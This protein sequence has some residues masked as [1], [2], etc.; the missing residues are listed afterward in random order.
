A[1]AGPPSPTPRSTTPKTG[2]SRP[3]FL[4]RRPDDPDLRPE[5]A[6]RQ[7]KTHRVLGQQP[8]FPIQIDA[9][10]IIL[11]RQPGHFDHVRR[12]SG[13]ALKLGLKIDVARLVP[14]SVRVSD[15]GRHQLLAGAQQVHVVF[16]LSGQ[17]VQHH[18]A[19]PANHAPRIT[20][21]K[22]KPLPAGRGKAVARASFWSFPPAPIHAKEPDTPPPTDA[23]NPTSG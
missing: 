21:A 11:D 15:V 8:R 1:C 14:G 9:I 19:I 3:S 22:S 12:Q 5:Q 13:R 17:P 23:C 10:P 20:R 6:R 18:S 16:E 7:L 2:S 4:D